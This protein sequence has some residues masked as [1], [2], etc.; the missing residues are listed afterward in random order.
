M[1]PDWL[2]AGAVHQ[3]GF[4]DF[5]SSSWSYRFGSLIL[6]IISAQVNSLQLSSHRIPCLHRLVP[7]DDVGG[8]DGAELRP[9]AHA[10]LP[11]ALAKLSP[12]QL[13]ALVLLLGVLEKLLL[14]HAPIQASI[15]F[16][17]ILHSAEH[18]VGLFLCRR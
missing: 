12:R 5:T 6:L 2:P 4:D 9:H 8:L 16:T 7:L 1:S 11:L 13:H 14:I 3:F 15:D 10:R 18:S 17:L